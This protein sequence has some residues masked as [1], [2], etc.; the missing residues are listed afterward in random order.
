MD[1]FE[2]LGPPMMLHWRLP[3]VPRCCSRLHHT[4]SAIIAIHGLR[5]ELGQHVVGWRE[6]VDV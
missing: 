1:V 6:Y 5:G 3:S 2:W 4:V